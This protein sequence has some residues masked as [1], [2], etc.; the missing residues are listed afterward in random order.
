LQGFHRLGLFRFRA[1]GHREVAPGSHALQPNSA[2]SVPSGL[3]A[4]DMQRLAGHERRLLEVD[5]GTDEVRRG[6]TLVTITSTLVKE[7]K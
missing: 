4:V 2:R 6:A 3:A 5:E 1:S 7:K